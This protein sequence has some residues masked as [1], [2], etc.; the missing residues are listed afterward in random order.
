[1][2]SKFNKYLFGGAM[3]GGGAA[4]LLHLLK[5][6][7]ADLRESKAD[8]KRQHSLDKIG[9]NTIV[10]HAPLKG[11]EDLSYKTDKRSNRKKAIK[12]KIVSKG[13]SE[14]D[15]PVSDDLFSRLGLKAASARD[16]F[17]KEV[18]E[19]DDEQPRDYSGR[20]V[21]KN[22][23]S[24]KKAES[25]STILG[26]AMKTQTAANL[27]A[28][29]GTVGSFI[30]ANKLLNRVREARLKKEIEMA[31]NEY[32]DI[33]NGKVPQKSKKLAEA[34]MCTEDT[35]LEKSAGITSLALTAA[36]I[37][38]LMTAYITKKV[39]EKKLKDNKKKPEL[40]EVSKVIIK[41]S[42]ADPF[43]V[44]P[45]VALTYID[46]AYNAIKNRPIEKTAADSSAIP[47][48]MDVANYIINWAGTDDDRI[49][50]ILDV[51]QLSEGGDYPAV[52]KYLHD[53]F[54]DT[55]LFR[56]FMGQQIDKGKD[57]LIEAGQQIGNGDLGDA[58]KTVGGYASDAVSSGSKLY[59]FLRDPEQQKKYF[60]N[61][62]AELGNALIASTPERKNAYL[63]VLGREQNQKF[64][65]QHVA[66]MIDRK[67]GDSGFKGFF[68]PI[69]KFLYK[70]LARTSIGR[71]MLANKYAKIVGLPE[72][73]LNNYA[74]YGNRF[75]PIVQESQ[76]AQP[77]AQTQ[78]PAQPK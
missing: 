72:H 13:K 69:V 78:A 42:S 27:A 41:S 48:S 53:N 74:Y 23:M 19:S 68:A 58:G 14:K 50:K 46:I 11:K 64:I 65:D 51:Y 32:I 45:G 2:S 3:V 67:M 37:P 43:E 21:S 36:A 26:K 54:S 20:F 44:S 33:I 30:L 40:P 10:I 15:V 28:L 63:R 22:K 75:V 56:E 12:R 4:S 60:K 16:S 61:M 1:M 57:A 59:N 34:L 66:R 52:T 73:Y 55:D 8:E 47:S 39:L 31:Q 7:A 49:Q 17:I 5:G 70:Y 76:K 38:T 6:F 62:P 24:E 77:A 25:D 9:P 71:R 18:N 35:T 29:G